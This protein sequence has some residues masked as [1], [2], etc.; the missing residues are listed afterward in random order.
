MSYSPVYAASWYRSIICHISS[1]KPCC[2]D[3]T[4]YEWYIIRVHHHRHK[5]SIACAFSMLVWGFEAGGVMNLHVENGVSERTRHRNEDTKRHS[6]IYA[7]MSEPTIWCH[8]PYTVSNV[9]YITF[10]VMIWPEITWC[11]AIPVSATWTIISMALVFSM[12][13]PCSP[14]FKVGGRMPSNT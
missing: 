5:T 7:E 10:D 3:I 11:S 13:R 1:Y 6:I 4:N 2:D 14:Y 9:K 8:V 12:S